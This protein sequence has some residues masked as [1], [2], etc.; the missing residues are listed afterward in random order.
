MSQRVIQLRKETVEEPDLL[1]R[2]MPA[3]RRKRGVRG[4]LLAFLLLAC[5][6]TVAAGVYLYGFAADQ[7]VAEFRFNLRRAAE[8][9]LTGGANSGSPTGALVATGLTASQI[10]DSQTIVQF[11]RSRDVVDALE[12]ELGFDRLYRRAEVDWVS[13]LGEARSIERKTEYWRGMVEPFFDAMTG[14]ISVSVRAFTPE[15]ALAVANAVLKSAEKTVNELS[16][17]AQKDAIAFGE[18]EV[19]KADRRL[20]E[21]RVAV[22]DFR[23]KAE[24]VDP[25]RSVEVD[26]NL[27]AHQRERLAT[28]Q[29]QYNSISKS[30]P[31]SPQLRHLGV[32]IAA[33]E[34]IIRDQQ[35]GMTQG[36]KAV[37]EKSGGPTI[38]ALM[39]GYEALKLEEAF[40][41]K[42]Y[43]FALQ[44]AEQS[45]IEAMRQKLYLNAFVKPKLPEEALY[46]RRLRIIAIV[47]VVGLV[48]WGLGSLAYYSIRDHL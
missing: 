4:H 5:V 26:I 3:V 17:R 2:P 34:G 42:L 13:R 18:E 21:A 11:I 8:P 39:G 25:G 38:T 15:D 6:P 12:T 28:L 20:V 29:A 40:R 35:A 44:F 41:E 22:R 9:V 47:F 27:Q 19:A 32:E 14:V 37:P 16:T 23:D 46:P 31:N 30:A 33:I 45:R 36:R 1:A 10:W 48:A 24:M 43:L 7:Y